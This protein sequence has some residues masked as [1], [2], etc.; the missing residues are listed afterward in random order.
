MACRRRSWASGDE[1][2]KDEKGGEDEEAE[3]EEEEDDDDGGTVA[4]QTVVVVGKD[5]DEDEEDEDR[6]GENVQGRTP[7]GNGEMKDD[8]VTTEV[9]RLQ[10]QGQRRCSG[11]ES[12]FLPEQRQSCF[13]LS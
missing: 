8:M 5:E 3:E 13:I 9:V 12:E 4:V 7:M 2:E 1:N 6:N 11:E 10:W